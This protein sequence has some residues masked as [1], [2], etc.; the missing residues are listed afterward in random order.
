MAYKNESLPISS[1][2]FFYPSAAWLRPFFHDAGTYVKGGVKNKQGGPNGSLGAGCPNKDCGKP[3][4]V[5]VSPDPFL[6]ANGTNCS[7][8]YPSRSGFSDG[9]FYCCPAGYCVAHGQ[10][11]NGN[12][13]SGKLI[14]Q[15][16]VGS[17][18]TNELCRPENDSLM[19]TIQFFRNR[20]NDPAFLLPDGSRV[21]LADIIILGAAA[22][23]KSCSGADVSISL[24]VGRPEAIVAD[25]MPLPSPSGLINDKHFSIFQAMGLNKNDMVTTVV[26]SHSIGGFRAANNPGVTS[27][28]FVPFDC[29]PAGQWGAKPFD[30]NV[31]KVACDG[32]KGVT[33]GT[34][35]FNALCTLAANETSCP[36]TDD[37]KQAYLNATGCLAPGATAL[38]SPG[39]I[40]DKYLCQE[41]QPTR[42]LMVNY[43]N[44]QTLFFQEYKAAFEKMALLGYDTSTLASI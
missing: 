39:L 13:Q 4:P 42:Q 33:A 44:N 24:L 27:C 20:Q 18:D 26:G 34:C 28:P 6:S 38:P 5:G 1:S 2:D 14:P 32:V 11:A 40:S 23:V 30:N 31:F 15:C 12:S 41:S 35:T 8:G 43:A 17:R 10:T 7:D 22:A 16:L 9:N 29:T 19:P 3:P 25:V 21:S 37:V 36:I